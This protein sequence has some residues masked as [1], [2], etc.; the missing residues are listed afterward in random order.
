MLGLLWG[1]SATLVLP[2]RKDRRAQVLS[3]V[4][5]SSSRPVTRVPPPKTWSWGEHPAVL[6]WLQEA[7]LW[8]DVSNG[9]IPVA[10][11]FREISAVSTGVGQQ[12]RV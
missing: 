4:P 2:T 8:P 6:G 5:S 11:P 3:K 12:H 1:K 9:A 10:P 7:F